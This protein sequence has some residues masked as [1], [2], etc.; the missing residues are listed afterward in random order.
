MTDTIARPRLKITYATLRADNEGLHEQFERGVE[1]ARAQLGARHAN[2]VDGQPRNGEGEFED[3]SPI[4]HELLVGRFAKGTRQ[5]VRD[6]IAAA[7]AAAPGWAG[8]P[9][10]ERV[11][12]LRRAAD[13]ISERQME[14]AALMCYEVGKNR[15]E[16]LGD[17][18][19]TADLIR[20]YCDR[21]EENDGF[22]V[23]MGNLGDRAVHTRSVLKPHGVFAVISPFN[24]PLALCGGPAGAALVAGN[25]VVFKPSSDAPLLGLKLY[26]VLR[27]A[28]LPTGAF[29]YVAGPGESVGAEL[30]ENEDIDGIVFTGSYEVGFELYKTFAR[31]YPKPVI[32]EMGGKNP[33]IVSRR[34]D[35]EEAAEGIMRA[36]FGFGGQ[37]CSACSRVYV[38]R[39]VHDELV[40]Q[41]V[42]KTAE[43]SIGDPVQRENWLGPVIN[44][45]AVARFQTAVGE[46][47]REGSIAIG[48]ERL[49]G[50]GLDRGWFVEP[51]IATGVPT[52][53]RLFRDELFVPFVAVAAVD[54]IDQ[55]LAL[56][57]ASDYALTAG[58]F[59]ED[60]G[61]IE[62]FLERIHAGVVYVNRRAGATTGAWPGIQP[63]GGW[64]ASGSTG[65]AGGGLYYLQQ[66]MREQSQT[67]VD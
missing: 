67:I 53:H 48:G 26:D 61:E 38:E 15:L 41:L 62:R 47:R 50:N 30:Q 45:R 52:D 37:K 18:E 27:E 66:F 34:A 3:R 14:Y 51:T 29:N 24:F 17:V 64:K 4:D 20:Y 10:Q 59:S 5:D 56:A 6:A 32:V 43:I 57:N 35:I 7:R 58:F 31:R 8:T 44:D 12:I 54:S 28:G 36:A 16:A 2:H 11:A 13:L 9:W 42:G 63:F 55:G 39:P 23:P 1:K 19:E 21:M 25:T 65:K 33:A 49:T 46:A 60:G 40:R 22:D